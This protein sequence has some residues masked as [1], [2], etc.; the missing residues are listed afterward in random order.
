MDTVRKRTKKQDAEVSL[1][2]YGKIP[3]Q[4]VEVEEVVLGALMLDKNA[5]ELISET[6]KPEVFY[7]ESHQQIFT[8]ISNL[9]KN[10]APIDILTV[11][12]ELKRLAKLDVAGGPYYIAQLTTKVASGANIEYHSKILK[13]KWISRELIRI[14][15]EI[16]QRAFEDTDDVFETIDFANNELFNVT[17]FDNV[18]VIEMSENIKE[19][20]KFIQLTAEGV[21]TGI[22]T[23]L[24][25]V[26]NHTKGLQPSD[27][28]IIAAESSQGK[29]ALALNMVY[30]AITNGYPVF[31]A[32]YEMSNIQLTGRLVSVGCEMPQDRIK[33][34]YFTTTEKT[35]YE[36][37]LQEINDSE[38]YLY[39]I[40][41]NKVENLIAS[42]RKHVVKFG[43]KLAV[44]DYLQLVSG[45]KKKNREQEI[46]E[47]S[48]LLKNTAKELNIHIMAL[49]QL[50]REKDHFPTINRLRDSGQIVESADNVILIY[51]QSEFIREGFSETYKDGT[52]VDGVAKIIFA[53]GR[54][55]GTTDFYLKFKKEITKFSD[56]DTF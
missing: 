6:L 25:A 54:N 31:F 52:P 28:T 30:F 17:N 47:I 55:I 48:R 49:S 15:G 4:S 19:Y 12:D 13:Q 8:A 26:D 14:S 40:K 3:P 39:D 35:K 42:I 7:K 24:I 18:K 43:I 46:G 41:N 50:S 21:L 22:P 44:V 5:F 36:Q 38:L 32:S 9:Y 45:D 2:Q 51:R 34:Q 29:T 53:K 23:G 10:I 27:L 56:Y 11:T 33:E 37:I 20:L 16:S 1:L